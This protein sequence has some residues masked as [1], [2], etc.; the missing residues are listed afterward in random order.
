MCPKFTGFT[1][2][3]LLGV[4]C[5]KRDYHVNTRQYS[6]PCMCKRG[7]IV[8][9]WKAKGQSYL[10]M[11]SNPLQA[12][13]VQVPIVRVTALPTLDHLLASLT[14]GGLAED[15]VLEAV[16]LDGPEQDLGGARRRGEGRRRAGVGGAGRQ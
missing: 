14:A 16:G 3:T 5:R 12:G 9:S 10:F 4:P 6:Q 1:A 8:K 2:N 13:T 15:V 11:G 7:R